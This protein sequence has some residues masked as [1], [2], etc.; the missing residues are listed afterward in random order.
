MVVD[1]VDLTVWQH[2][3]FLCKD[4]AGAGAILRILS[5]GRIQVK[6][7]LSPVSMVLGTILCDMWELSIHIKKA[8]VICLSTSM[9]SSPVTPFFFFHF[10][11]TMLA[12]FLFINHTKHTDFSK[13]L[14]LL[15]PWW[16]VLSSIHLI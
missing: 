9:T 3:I 6:C 8:Y 16:S 14:D 11:S 2:A 7:W 1:K 4:S 13:P 15:V 12:F 10:V 5:A